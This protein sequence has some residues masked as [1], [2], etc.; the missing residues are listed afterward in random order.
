MQSS[1]TQYLSSPMPN[2]IFGV[3]IFSWQPLTFTACEDLRHCQLNKVVQ[4]NL[5]FGAQK[6]VTVSPD[7]EPRQC[8]PAKGY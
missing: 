7:C 1:E 5:A 3:F 6:L 4:S 8:P 2:T